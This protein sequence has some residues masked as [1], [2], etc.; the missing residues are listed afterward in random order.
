MQIGAESAGVILKL[1]LKYGIKR[2]GVC[3]SGSVK[4]KLEIPAGMN[5][6]G[7]VC[8]FFGKSSKEH[9]ANDTGEVVCFGD[10]GSYQIVETNS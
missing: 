9:R 8:A 4:C 3:R 6:K 1:R 2:L 7:D 10:K 5:R